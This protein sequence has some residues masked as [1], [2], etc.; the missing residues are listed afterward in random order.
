MEKITSLEQYK[1]LANRTCPNLGSYQANINHMEDGVITEFSELLDP[2]KKY[3]AY[4]KAI[5]IINIQ[6]ELGDAMWY[7]ANSSIVNGVQFTIDEQLPLYV[8]K[9]VEQIRSYIKMVLRDFL[10]Y[11]NFRKVSYHIFVLCQSFELDFYE[12]LT[13]NINK[14]IVRY[15]EKFDTEKAM[16]RDLDAERLALIQDAVD[17]ALERPIN[18]GDQKMRQG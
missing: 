16:N 12:T 9:E 15:P 1:L 17:A 2:I 18:F 13:K 10:Q 11:Q 7:C 8:P 6:E 14:L 3:C 5:D 4:G